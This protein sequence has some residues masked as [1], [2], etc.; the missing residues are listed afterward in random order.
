MSLILDPVA[1]VVFVMD[2]VVSLF[3]FSS[4]PANK[5]NEPSQNFCVHRTN[6]RVKNSIIFHFAEIESFLLCQ[7][8]RRCRHFGNK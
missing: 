5:Q 3:G 4:P 7:S 6:S 1:I 8:R 2:V